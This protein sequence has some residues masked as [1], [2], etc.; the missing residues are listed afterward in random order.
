MSKTLKISAIAASLLVSGILVGCGSSN[1]GGTTD[2]GTNPGTATPKSITV[3]D[4]Y[5]LSGNVYTVNDSVSRVDAANATLP[6]QGSPVEGVTTKEVGQGVYQISNVKPSDTIVSKQGIVDL[7]NNG[8]VD[9]G[10]PYALNMVASGK[11]LYVN[12]FTTIELLTNAD[13]KELFGI[14]KVDFDT[15]GKADSRAANDELLNIRKAVAYAN[16]ILF[17][18]QYNSHKYGTSDKDQ[19]TD[20]NGSSSYLP[21][22]YKSTIQ[23]IVDKVKQT[24]SSGKTLAEAISVLTG[25]ESY[26]SLNTI[27]EV[28]DLIKSE[29]SKQPSS[30][31]TGG[32]TDP[33]DTNTGYLPH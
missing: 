10:E 7:N 11:Y 18:A 32:T 33:E 20:Q 2:P 6:V 26:K 12:P 23:I 4:D 15:S 13:V 5:V 3:T 22:S 8:K 25:N 1:D 9:A 31:S 17:E 27:S 29:L 21:Q 14:Q 16:A 19:N 30:S 24:M 28:N